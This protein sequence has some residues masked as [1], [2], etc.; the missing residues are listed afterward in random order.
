MNKVY[1]DKHDEKS[2][3][4]LKQGSGLVEITFVKAVGDITTG[5][6]TNP[7]GIPELVGTQIAP[8]S[9]INLRGT[10]CRCVSSLM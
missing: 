7:D 9:N 5:S 6:A 3:K 10:F 2:T 1:A 4:S 8:P